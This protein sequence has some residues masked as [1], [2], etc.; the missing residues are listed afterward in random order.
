MKYHAIWYSSANKVRIF[1]VDEAGNEEVLHEESA[2][3]HQ[4]AAEFVKEQGFGFT[5]LW[6]HDS[7]TF[8]Y[9]APLKAM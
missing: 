2:H 1:E 3:D 4:V 8:N 5:D 9:Q 7:K 6:V